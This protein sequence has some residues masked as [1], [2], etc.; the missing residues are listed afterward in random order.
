MDR[1]EHI[2][3]TTRL[4]E[5]FA[6]HGATTDAQFIARA[7]E[8]ITKVKVQ[9]DRLAKLLEAKRNNKGSKIST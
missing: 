7:L 8:R 4:L 5:L 6:K 2:E 9:G 3:N 1:K